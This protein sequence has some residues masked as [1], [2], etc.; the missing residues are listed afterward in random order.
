[1]RI[2]V[3]LKPEKDN[4]W[5]EINDALSLKPGKRAKIFR[6]DYNNLWPVMPRKSSKSGLLP[7]RVAI[8]LLC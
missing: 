8:A 2:G 3:K 5:N 4:P 1:M 7:A 6:A